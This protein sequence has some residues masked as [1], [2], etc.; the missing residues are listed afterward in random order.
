MDIS[1]SIESKSGYLSLVDRSRAIS[2]S[3]V[4]VK[5]SMLMISLMLVS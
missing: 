5:N 2:P 3:I 4:V 1:V